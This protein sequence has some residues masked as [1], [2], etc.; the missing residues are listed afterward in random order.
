MLNFWFIYSFK[1]LFIQRIKGFGTLDGRL[2]WFL[3]WLGC[4]NKD[5]TENAHAST[6]HSLILL[7]S[8][9]LIDS[10]FHNLHLTMLEFPHRTPPSGCTI[11]RFQLHSPKRE[12]FEH[13]CP[14]LKAD[15]YNYSCLFACEFTQVSYREK[16][17]IISSLTSGCCG[18]SSAPGGPPVDSR[19]YIY[20]AC[21]ICTSLRRPLMEVWH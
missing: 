2:F 8:G 15:T 13:Q 17:S 5:A 10:V 11:H 14:F 3:S 6:L 7:L 9:T 12:P 4:N 21:Y 1:R 18:S 16:N 19:C 20:G